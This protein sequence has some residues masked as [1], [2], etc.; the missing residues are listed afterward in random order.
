MSAVAYLDG[1]RVF[2][3]DGI[4][5]LAYYNDWA[6]AKGYYRK[7]DM[8]TMLFEQGYS[9]EQVFEEEMG[10]DEIFLEWCEIWGVLAY[11]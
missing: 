9:E 5:T 3:E 1:V 2:I 7:E 11:D 8:R 10:M 6:V 4:N